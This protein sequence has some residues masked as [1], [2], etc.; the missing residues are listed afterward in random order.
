ME[1]LS[2]I[3]FRF[4]CD[5]DKWTNLEENWQTNAIKNK[6]KKNVHGITGNKLKFVGEFYTIECTFLALE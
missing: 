2:F 1:R 5:F 3:G 4:R 6:K